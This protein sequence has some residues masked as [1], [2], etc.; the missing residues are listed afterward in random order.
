[1]RF[2]SNIT[3]SFLINKPPLGEQFF[4][5]KQYTISEMN[6]IENNNCGSYVEFMISRSPK[7]NHEALLKLEKKSAEMFTREGVLYD[8]FL[9]GNNTSW[10]GFTNISKMVSASED[11]EVW[12]N[13]LSYKDKKHRDEFVTKMSD[14]KECQEGYEQFTKLITPGSEIITGEF[15]RL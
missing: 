7:K 5:Y 6:K 11:E 2:A 10:E 9:V 8:L 14:N 1:L 4:L 3:A 12:F 15:T 13:M